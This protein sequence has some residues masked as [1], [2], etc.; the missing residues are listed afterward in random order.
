MEHGHLL[1]LFQP[2]ELVIIGG[3]ALGT[4]LIANPIP[5]LKKI[6]SGVLGILKGNP[7]TKALYTDNLKM[8]YDLFNYAR[9]SGTA[10]LE[11]DVDKPD[12]SQIFSKHPAF[13]KNHHATHFLCDTLR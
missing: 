8:L 13:L 11:E 10:K 9:K 12:K 2:A 7:Y 3:A 5:V 6:I 4:V 1:V